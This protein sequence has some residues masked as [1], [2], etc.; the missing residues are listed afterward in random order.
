[1]VVVMTVL[2]WWL[3]GSVGISL[4]LG[5]LMRRRPSGWLADDSA[6]PLADAEISRPS[7]AHLHAPSLTAAARG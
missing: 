2:A 7:P 3:A 1:M 6:F 4:A 5:Q